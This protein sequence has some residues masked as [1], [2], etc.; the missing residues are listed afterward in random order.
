[1]KKLVVPEWDEQASWLKHQ[2]SEATD[3]HYDVLIDEPT[4]VFVEGHA[5]PFAAYGPLPD[6]FD[7]DGDLMRTAKYGVGVRTTGK[8]TTRSVTFGWVPR[9]VMRSRD[10]AAPSKFNTTF[11]ELYEELGRLGTCM[12]KKFATHVP[13]QYEQQVR[14]LKDEVVEDYRL[15]DTAFTGGILNLDCALEYHRDRGNFKD[16]WNIMGVW[17]QHTSGGVTVLPG[18]RLGFEMANNTFFLFPAQ[19]V[20]HGVTKITKHRRD[21]Y[22]IS[23]VYFATMGLRHS[24]PVEEERRRAR[25]KRTEREQRRAGLI[26]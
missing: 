13:E 26:P 2:F 21:A 19:S 25:A 3:D 22:R 18:P 24:L 12:G 15:G 17:K 20:G 4:E 1:M 23:A 8:L 6:E 10:Y 5:D 9:T 14:L 16:S 7:K 11:P